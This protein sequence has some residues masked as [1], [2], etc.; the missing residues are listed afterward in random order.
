MRLRWFQLIAISS[1]ALAA[2]TLYA[3]RRPRYGGTLKL[4]IGS[5]LAALDPQAS[6]SGAEE[7]T[8][9]KALLNLI[10]E[11]LVHLD[12][13]ARP[14]PDLA[15][16][17]R[18]SPDG[19]SWVFVLRRNVSLQD[20]SLLAPADVVNSLLAAAPR[21]KVEVQGDKAAS[22]VLVSTEAPEPD[23]PSWLARAPY[24]IYRRTLEGALLGTGPFRLAEWEP[25]RHARFAANGSYWGGRPFL[26]SIDLQMGVAVRERIIDL[27]LRKADFATLPAE[28][29]R[30]AG[31]QGIRVTVTPSAELLALTLFPGHIA[32]EDARVRQALAL[33]IDRAGL[34]S[35][36]LQKQGEP[37]GSLLPQWLS[38]TAFLFQTTP[39]L[40]KAR[41]LV[42]Q[43][44]SATRLRLGYDSSSA[45]EQ[46]VAERIAVNARDA[47]LSVVAQARTPANQSSFEAGLLWLPIATPVPRLAL[48]DL[49]A[50]LGLFLGADS[51]ALPPKAAAEEIYARERAAVDS[52]RVIPLVHL[53][54]VYGVGPR[55][56][57]WIAPS[58]PGAGGTPFADVWLEEDAR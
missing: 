50:R 56:R 22:A 45:L 36:I 43:A 47:G 23:L 55:V 29:A 3:A 26:D 44:G 17:W 48:S 57:D 33:S 40:A 19:K 54:D 25:R 31:E 27:E 28:M 21:W 8:D 51:A 24:W 14:Q 46:A 12:E 42:S 5:S 37:A 18:V 2:A 4:E 38:G 11:G 6:A 13:H 15:E 52:F 9:R 10:F 53:P 30:R 41:A 58:F 20:G 7:A 49:L 1:A 39:D 35:L 34:A 32:A 16:S